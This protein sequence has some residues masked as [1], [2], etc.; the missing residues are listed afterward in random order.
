[1][2]S[3]SN[4]SSVTVHSSPSLDRLVTPSTGLPRSSCIC[5]AAR[6]AISFGLALPLPDSAMAHNLL[7]QRRFG[8]LG[9]FGHATAGDGE[10]LHQLVLHS[11]PLD[12]SDPT[13]FG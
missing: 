3:S 10:S 7:G 8:Q 12:V 5:S 1:M 13:L 2:R 9:L 6:V 11:R 4:T